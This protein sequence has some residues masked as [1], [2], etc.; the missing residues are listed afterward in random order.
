MYYVDINGCRYTTCVQLPT[1]AEEDIA[2]P[3]NWPLQGVFKYDVGARNSAWD[4]GKS[5]FSLYC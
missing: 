2:F 5:K 3:K 4:L 1:Q